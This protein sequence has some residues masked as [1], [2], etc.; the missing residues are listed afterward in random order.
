MATF[1]PDYNGIGQMLRSD[2]IEAEMFR[3]AKKV[4]EAAEAA[5]PYDPKSIT[6]YR[7]A[8]RLQ[9]NSRGGVHHDR[10]VASVVNDDPAAF[11]IEYGTSKTPQ[12]RTLRNALDA[13]R[14]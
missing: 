13:A 3:R 12:H 2:F 8:F 1:T 6:H 10:A 9:V 11:F 5:A 4:L 7:D 14:D